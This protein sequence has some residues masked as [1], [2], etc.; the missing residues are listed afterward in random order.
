MKKY[1]VGALT[2]AVLAASACS[3]KKTEGTRLAADTPAYNLAKELATVVPIF[4]PDKNAVLIN[5]EAFTVTAGDVVEVIQNTMGN[6]AA[7]LKD[8]DVETLKRAVSQ[9]AVQIGER[10]L[11]LA[12]A[13]SAKITAKVEDVDKALADQYAQAGGEEAFLNMLKANNVDVAFV[14]KTIGEDHQIQA[15]LDAKVFGA[16]QISEE[17]LQKAYA[18]DKTA[19]VRHILLMTQ[20]KP[21]EEI[22]AIRKKMEDILARA[23][24]GEDFAALAKEYTEDTGS[25]ESGGLYENFPKGQMVK[26]FEDA[27]FTVP[28]G[29]ISD[30]VQTRYGLHILKIESRARETEPFETVKA[31]LEDQLKQSRK[32]GVYDEFISGLKAKAKFEEVKF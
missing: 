8:R 32:A 1:L 10:K 13:V 15:F 9:T 12:E 24:K 11:L 4:D 7:S 26:E 17:D 16:V 18:A 6:A 21:A 22:P 25:K 5:T 19:S 28:V 29:E 31:S 3:P 2:L 14:K 23:K 27:A 30:I 20:D